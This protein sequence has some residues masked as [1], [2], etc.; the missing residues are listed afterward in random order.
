MRYAL[1][2]VTILCAYVLGDTAIK[3]MKEVTEQRNAQICQI[4]PTLCQSN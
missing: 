4:D 3:N 2:L 1:I